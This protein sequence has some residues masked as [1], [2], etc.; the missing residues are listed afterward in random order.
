MITFLAKR[1]IT[2]ALVVLIS[3]LIMYYLVAAAINPLQKFQGST[4]PNRQQQIDALTARLHLNEP[5]ITRYWDWLK[6][7][8]G[9]L[10]GRC[11]LGVDWEKNQQVTEQ[12]SGAI[13]TTLE[14][15]L[16]ATALAIVFGIAVGLVS[17]L[18]QYSGF[19]YSITFVSFLLFSL[20]TFW[21]AVLAKYYLAIDFND[22]LAD[23]QISVWV[24]AGA[25]LATAVIV[26]AALGGPVSR[27]LRTGGIALFLVVG[28]CEYANA[29]DFFERPSRGGPLDLVMVSLAALGAAF[30]ITALTTG[31]RNRRALYSAISVAVIG[32]ALY[33]P[34]LAFWNS[35]DVSWPLVLGLAVLAV[36]V[37]AGIGLA[38]RGPDPARSAR[39]AAL[40][41]FVV[42]VFLFVDR[43]M[44]SWYA[45]VHNPQ[46]KGRPIATLGSH[47]PNLAGSFWIHTLDTLT[48]LLLPTITLVLI[49]FAAYTRYTRASM[50]EVMNQDYVRTARSKGLTER[51]VVMRHAF[52]NALLPLAS[53]VPVDIITVIGGAIFTETIFGWYGM[54]RLF[55]DAL[56]NNIQDTVM[57][58]VLIVGILAVVA[59]IVADVLYAVLDPRIRVN[60]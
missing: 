50:L 59:N 48:H 30:G 37:G 35:V 20:P 44:Q 39:T 31:L 34:M 53:I 10:Y 38:F 12:L 22:F 1:L 23:P 40:T 36:V 6:G 58:Y 2:S 41:A 28:L 25:G 8:V 9:C 54:G 13:A 17:A 11:N 60:A 49:Q 21:V 26:S 46:I 29:R 52:R 33:Y 14:L 15:V 16:A 32:I 19:D 27:R 4:A 47:T 24:I 55:V 51:T 57:A 7:A 43:L 3:S 56:R 5:V 42:A 45:Y 18:R